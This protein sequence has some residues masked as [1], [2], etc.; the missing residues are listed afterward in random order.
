M[1]S[2]YR[3][4]AMIMPHRIIDTN[5]ATMRRHQTARMTTAAICTKEAIA[6]F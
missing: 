2:G 5:G 4:T 1:C 6:F 3:A